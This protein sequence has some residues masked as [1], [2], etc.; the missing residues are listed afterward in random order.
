MTDRHPTIEEILADAQEL[1]RQQPML[2]RIHLVMPFVIVVGVFAVLGFLGVADQYTIAGLAAL[3]VG[4]FII[5][6]GAVGE[7]PLNQWK[8]AVMVVAMDTWVAYVLAYNLHRVYR[9]PRVG[10]WLHDVQ[11]YCRYWL[12]EMPWIR[13]WAITGVTLFVIFPLSGTGAPGGAL[14]GRIVGL[15]PRVTLLAV[16]TG[17]VIGCGIMAAFAVPLETVFHGLTGEWWFKASGIAIL[18]ILLLILW[19]LG[20]RVSRAAQRFARSNTQQGDGGGR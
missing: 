7:N 12:H 9:I 5:L 14:L 16:F 17:S 2:S 4:K 18:V 19:R 15:R 3:P 8:L 11:N 6:S 13:R 20:V 10:P 1:E